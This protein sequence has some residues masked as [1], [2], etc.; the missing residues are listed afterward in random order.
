MNHTHFVKNQNG[1]YMRH[2]ILIVLLLVGCGEV[3]NNTDWASVP[4]VDDNYTHLTL[5]GH[6]TLC[7]E[8]PESE[9]C[10]SDDSISDIQPTQQYCINLA[11]GLD[12]NL[13]YV[14]T[15]EWYYNHTIYQRLVG[16][17]E[18]V[19]MTLAKH[20]IDDGIDKKH[21]VMVYRLTGETS[22]H[23]FLAINTSDAGWIHL[24]YAN[25]GGLLEPQINHHMLLT[26]AGVYK[27]IKG[28]IK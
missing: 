10:W 9:F 18:D 16:D 11:K 24:D 27:W 14:V 12:T 1:N 20:M 21:I 4:Y 8:L 15:D 6:R 17:C 7:N 19:A 23:I 5:K 26:D 13:K 25:S 22:A 3:N 2:M 28:N